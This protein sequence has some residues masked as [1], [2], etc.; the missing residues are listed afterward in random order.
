MHFIYIYIYTHTHCRVVIQR[1]SLSF[2]DNIYAPT[3]WTEHSSGE[4]T[5]NHIN[6]T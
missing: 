1:N 6:L 5:S 4:F 3:A 2:D